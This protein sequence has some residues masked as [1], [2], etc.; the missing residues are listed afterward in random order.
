M[1]IC[2]D[3]FYC[4]NRAIAGAAAFEDWSASEPLAEAIHVE[5]QCVDY[6]PGEFFRRELP[7]IR[8]VLQRFSATPD[9]V[10]VDGYVW[11]EDESSP[12][13]G[14]YLYTHLNQQSRVIGVA[15]KPYRN[16][17]T[18]VPVTRGTSRRPLFVTAAGIDSATAADYIRKMHGEFR[19]P[20]MLRF[21][22][23]MGRDF[24]K[25][26]L[27]ATQSAH[28]PKSIAGSD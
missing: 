23:Q 18:A 8:Q 5:Y 15:K 1:I 21:V 24:A 9:V 12:G 22:D 13:L 25:R 16:S 10:I 19:I 17:S 20:T 11:L 3:V 6:V 26:T 7:A 28:S 2:I 27:S 14:A 4:D